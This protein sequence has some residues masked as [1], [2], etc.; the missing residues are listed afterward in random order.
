MTLAIYLVWKE[1]GPELRLYM[2]SH[3]VVNNL[4]DGQEPRKE[5]EN[6]R[7]TVWSKDMRLDIKKD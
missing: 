5:I 6:Q 3:A 7:E 4:A 2:E 1:K